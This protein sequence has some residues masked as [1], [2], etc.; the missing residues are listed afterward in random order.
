MDGKPLKCSFQLNGGDKLDSKFLL[1]EL[2]S[3]EKKENETMAEFNCRFV[4]ILS[5]IPRGVRP[6]NGTALVF[7]INA[8]DESFGF[9]L[10]DKDL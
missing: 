8:F 7:Y 3:I 6:G 5:R 4:K 10:R 9:L 2:T 1:A